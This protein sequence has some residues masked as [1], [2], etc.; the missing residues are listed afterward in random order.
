MLADLFVKLGKY[1]AAI[2][3]YLQLLAEPEEQDPTKQAQ[4]LFNLAQVVARYADHQKGEAV[5]GEKDSAAN[6]TLLRWKAVHLLK[7]SLA[8]DSTIPETHLNLSGLYLKLEAPHEAVLQAEKGLAL[9]SP[10]DKTLQLQLATNFNIALRQTGQRSRAVRWT[11][12]ALGIHFNVEDHLCRR[13]VAREASPVLTVVLVKWGSKYSAAY[14]TKLYHMIRAGWQASDRF[15]SFRVVCLTDDPSGLEVCPEIEV[16]P[17]LS[18]D[19]YGHEVAGWWRKIE[20][21]HTQTYMHDDVGWV[22]F[23][24]LDTVLMDFSLSVLADSAANFGEQ[25][26]KDKEFIFF[27][28]AAK[29]HN[30]GRPRGINSSLIMFLSGQFDFVFDVFLSHR[31]K[32][33]DYVLKFDHYME[34]LFDSA[35][36]DSEADDLA[37]KEREGEGS[38][39]AVNSSCFVL[40]GCVQDLPGGEDYVM[41]IHQALQKIKDGKSVQG[42]VCFPLKPKPHELVED[43]LIKRAW[44]QAGCTVKNHPM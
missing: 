7:R 25:H 26:H 28:D 10:D 29:F 20:V 35:F 39:T 31:A 17:L 8:A 42:M 27:L 22:L 34:M 16:H 37:R 43:S 41:D 44:D 36:G 18:A 1:P 19:Q 32:L 33:L 11:W 3:L 40:A 23:I 9:V 24:D 2:K 12:D 38:A 21:F 13:N 4:L 14:V 5:L 15:S 6:V 30:E